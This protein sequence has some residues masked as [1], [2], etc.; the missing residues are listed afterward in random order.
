MISIK[1]KM[2]VDII[3]NF[4][5][6]IF[7][8]V[9]GIFSFIIPN[10]IGKFVP[11]GASVVTLIS[12]MILNGSSELHYA[13]GETILLDLLVIDT[14]TKSFILIFALI[15]VVISIFGMDLQTR[16]ERG[17]SLIYAGGTFGVALAGDYISFIMFWEITLIATFFL[18][19]LGRQKNSSG[20][21]IRYMLVHAFGGNLL[22]AGVLTKLFQGSFLV[23]NLVEVSGVIQ[24]QDIGFWLILGGVCINA[25]V[26]PFHSWIADAYPEATL[27]GAVYMASFTTKVAIYAMIRFFAGF[28]ALLWMGVFMA[29][30]AAC[31]AIMENDLRRLLSYHIV[32][33]LG[34]IV[35]ALSV[36][37]AI[38]IDGAVAHVFTNIMFKGALLMAAGAVVYSTGKRKISELGG[39]Y[40]KM[41]I[42]AICFLIASLAIA[43]LPFLNGF[44]SKALI[45]DALAEDGDSL[46]TLGITL[47]GIGTLLSIT[48]KINYFVFFGK[49]DKDIAVKPIPKSMIVGI[50]LATGLCIVTGIYPDIMYG[51]LP[52]ATEVNPFTLHHILEY[53]GIFI[54]GTIPFAMYIKKMKPHD[55]I[56]LD[57]DWFY[58]KPLPKFIY[59]LSKYI[60][61]IYNGID[62]VL[63]R[64]IRFF[65]LRLSDPYQWTDNPNVSFE[66]EDR[67]IGS[68][69]GIIF[70][71]IGLLYFVFLIIK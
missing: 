66:N 9:I 21:A 33:Q 40:K 65:G 18:V 51:Y 35:A 60:I 38:G 13:V 39:L 3:N 8:F 47:A 44:A 61:M 29:I 37:S 41:P 64:G 20:A 14:L 22:L 54:G 28:E 46:A 7:L 4:H 53:I 43:G 67:T 69:I 31:M 19:F 48:L 70:I 34:M 5:P 1:I 50:V 55:E 62:K 30:F 23:G 11:I 12:V 32:S 52:N 36:G 27:T 71:L 45:M 63:L 15:F 59:A 25:A 10:K 2:G 24:P 57:F 56:T 6:G 26:P 49:S 16:V 17:F 68:L 42:V 58:R